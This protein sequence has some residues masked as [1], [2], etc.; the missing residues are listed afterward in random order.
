MHFYDLDAADRAIAQACTTV[1]YPE[2]MVVRYWNNG[3]C[4]E[5]CGY[6]ESPDGMVFYWEEIVV[7]GQIHDLNANEQFV[8]LI[9]PTLHPAAWVTDKRNEWAVQTPSGKW[10]ISDESLTW[11][12]IENRQKR[13]QELKWKLEEAEKAKSAA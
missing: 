4:V 1:M 11:K 10:M 3:D 2:P 8:T 13:R 6:D 7:V 5:G 12:D 9:S